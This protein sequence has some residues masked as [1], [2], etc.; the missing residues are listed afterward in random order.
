MDAWHKIESYFEVY[1]RY[2]APLRGKPVKMLEIGVARG[3]SIAGWK[4]YFGEAE[5][6]YTG[7]DISP[8]CSRFARA[9]VKIVIGDQMDRPL[10]TELARAGPYDIVID[11]G[12]HVTGQQIVSFEHLFGAVRDGGYYVVEDTH[13]SFWPS[14]H[15]TFTIGSTTIRGGFLDFAQV[16]IRS[17]MEFWWPPDSAARSL[18]PR[19][20]RPSL[21]LGPHAKEIYAISF[22]DSMV[23]IEKRAH[24]EPLNIIR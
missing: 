23:V 19:A 11:D 10:L 7:L 2:F 3:G 18:Q 22:Y 4:K 17:Q 12:G 16:L 21:D 1:D 13:T 14:F 9:G 8:D 5:L 6:D 20:S 24:P 15:S